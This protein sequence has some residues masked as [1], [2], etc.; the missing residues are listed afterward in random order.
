MKIYTIEYQYGLQSGE[1]EIRLHDDDDRDPCNVLWSR[2]A[3][4]GE[5]TMP[6]AYQSARIIDEQDEDERINR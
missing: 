1:R 6:M 4:S 3:R 5:L 2:M